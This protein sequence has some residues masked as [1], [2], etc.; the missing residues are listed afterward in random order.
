MPITRNTEERRMKVSILTI[1]MAF[2]LAAGIPFGAMAGP[3]PDVD[4]DT[5][6]DSVDN[7]LTL[8]NGANEPNPQCDTDSDG[9][10]NACDA[11]VN[12]DSIVGT[13][14]YAP[15]GANIGSPTAAFPGADVNCDGTIGTP[16]YAPVGS[17]I[18]AGLIAGPSGFTCAG[19]IPCP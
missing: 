11:D 6:P 15:I 2:L 17:G 7:C 16:D 9:Y 19:T 10:G 18:A 1:L 12:N 14:D 3:A 4:N 8:A 5:V 13:P